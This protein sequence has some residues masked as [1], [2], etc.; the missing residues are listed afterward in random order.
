[1]APSC[2][3]FVFCPKLTSIMTISLI[4]TLIASVSYAPFPNRIDRASVATM[5]TFADEVLSFLSDF[6]RFS[7]TNN[8]RDPVNR[9]T[10]DNTIQRLRIVLLHITRIGQQ[11]G[12]NALQTLGQLETS[13]SRV[14]SY[15][16]NLD[17]DLTTNT[18]TPRPNTG[19]AVAD[20]VTASRPTAHET[21]TVAPRVS[22]GI[23]P[24]PFN[25]SRNQLATLLDIGFSVASIARLR[26]LGAA[27]R[28]TIYSRMSEFNL[29]TVQRRYTTISDDDLEEAV[30]RINHE[31]QNSG[32]GEVWK[33]FTIYY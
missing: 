26:L 8:I 29:T 17:L 1:M 14:L 6:R 30:R 23:G 20:V 31:N 32:I 7:A 11:Q 9:V 22:N 33:C 21:L 25:I 4:I 12:P 13:L 2:S 16:E 19:T 24:P 10:V 3:G 15:L 28:Q 18:P 27:S 5:E